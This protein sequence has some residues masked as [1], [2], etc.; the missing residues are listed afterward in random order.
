MNLDTL[1]SSTAETQKVKSIKNWT[2]GNKKKEDYYDTA[3]TQF[4]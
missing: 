3:A 4:M 1:L 2:E